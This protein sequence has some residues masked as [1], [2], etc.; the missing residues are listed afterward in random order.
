MCIYG[1]EK[2]PTDEPMCTAGIKTQMQRTDLWAQEGKN[3]WDELR[4][5]H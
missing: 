1:I 3:G 5:Q 4:E 2:N